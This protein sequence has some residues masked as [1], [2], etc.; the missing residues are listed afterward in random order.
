MLPE[1]R[2]QSKPKPRG[3]A[4]MT[5]SQYR[6]VLHG[7]PSADTLLDAIREHRATKT[8]ATWNQADKR[9]YAHLPELN[10]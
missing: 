9:L 4:V 6:D 7:T 1:K 8:P 3:G 10:K 5:P 2:K